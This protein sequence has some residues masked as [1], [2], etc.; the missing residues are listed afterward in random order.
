MPRFLRD[1]RCASR[2]PARLRKKITMSAQQPSGGPAAISPWAPLE[3]PLFRALWIATVVSNVGTWMHEVGAGWLMVTLNPNPMMVSLVQAAAALPIFLLAL[4]AGALADIVDRRRYLIA[5]QAWMLGCAALLAALTL[6]GRVDAWSLLL[7]TFALAC[8]AAM[9]APAW[10]AMVPEL[11]PREELQP[12][13]AL[14][15]MGVNVARALGPALAGVL[16]AAAGP[17]VA[18]ALNAV[19][20]LGVIVVLGRWRRAAKVNTL[21]AERFLGATRAGLRYVR[22][23]PRLQAVMVRALVFFAFASASWALLPLVASQAGGGA[24]VYGTLLACI[25]AGAVGGAMVLPRLRARLTR[26]ALLRAATALYAVAMV[27]LATGRSL[28]VLIPA[29]LMIGVGWLTVVSS[30]HVS[31]QTSVP[32]WVRARALSIYMVMFAAG[33]T[34]GSVLWGAVAARSGISIALI[35]A[36]AGAVAALAAS[37]RVSLGGQ[38]AVDRNAPVAWPEPET[39]GEIEPDR[40]PVLITVEYRVAQENGA[41]FIAAAR[42]LRSIRRR[43]GAISWGLFH[44]AAEPERYVESFVVESWVEHMR[45]HQRATMADREVN[46]R[47]RAFHLGPEPP[48]VSHLIAAEHGGA[49]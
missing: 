45:Q 27:A 44:D 42:D 34:G 40:G 1:P 43:D 17:A 30:L 26:D 39:Y 9:M 46:E 3:R 14:N 33:M 35:A 31:A 2:Q 16:V 48:R 10:A 36:A 37:W 28:A 12:A 15:S 23:A 20:F 41:V 5:T 8:G 19:S 24:G 7:L 6:S 25:G 11:V 18:F 49:P 13:I 21:P 29:M 47:V 22:E 38:D 32:A 4:P